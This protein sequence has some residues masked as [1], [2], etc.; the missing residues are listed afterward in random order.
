M[1]S[2]FTR[3]SSTLALITV[4]LTPQFVFAQ[5]ILTATPVTYA[6]ATELT[7]KTN[8][9]TQYLPPKR[10]GIE[11]LPNWFST[12]G[13]KKAIESGKNATVAITLSSVW[14]A[15]PTYVYARQ[16]NVRLIEVDAAQAITPRAQGVAAITLSSGEVSKF[17]WLNPT[18][19][20][21][22]ASIVADDLKKVWPKYSDTIDANLQRVMLEV[23]ELINQQQAILL[24]REVDAVVLLSESLEDFVSGNQLFVEDRI[25]T[26]EL[27]WNKA[28]KTELQSLF[29]EDDSLWLV[30]SKKP[31][32][33]L[34][35]LVPENKILVIDSVDRWGKKGISSDKVF[36]RWEIIPNNQ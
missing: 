13:E 20:T 32:K 24:D 15:D 21:R 16:G 27:E 11:R 6:L 23:R 30:T 31:S 36:S 1:T 26:A 8:I 29:N 19:L 10:Y 18:N 25:F 28:Q 22:M 2:L 17:V 4:L 9:T 33:I 35:S 5:D 14:K 34:K 12:K 7:K 3:A